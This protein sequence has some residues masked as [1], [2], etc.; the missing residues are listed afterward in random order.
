MEPAQALRTATVDPAKHLGVFKDIGS[1]EKG[2]LADLVSL[3]A[4]PMDDI[5]NTDK[6][7]K[8]MLGGRLYDA[9]TMNETVTGTSKRAPYWWED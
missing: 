9:K 8:V 7:D 1:L 5:R 4:N 3:D 6:I 2:K